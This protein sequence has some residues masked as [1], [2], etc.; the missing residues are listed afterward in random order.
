M[1]WG[2]QNFVRVEH[3]PSGMTAYSDSSRSNVRCKKECMG[4]LRGKLWSLEH[5]AE[6]EAA[7]AA[8]RAIA[9]RILSKR[10]S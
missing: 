1:I 9:E 5:G 8:Q 3:L 7:T 6:P 2:P 10:Q 4:I